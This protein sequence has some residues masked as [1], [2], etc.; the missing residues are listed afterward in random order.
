MQPIKRGGVSYVGPFRGMGIG[1]PV[2]ICEWLPRSEPVRILAER[3][4]HKKHGSYARR[5][6]R[7]WVKRFGMRQLPDVIYDTGAA[8]L[9]SRQNYSMLQ[10]EL[11]AQGRLL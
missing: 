1:K 9:M 3:S 8:F 4:W 2:C 11:L 7:K 6:Q 10:R 5:V